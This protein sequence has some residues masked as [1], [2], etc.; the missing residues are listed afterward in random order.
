M[1]DVVGVDL[2]A[3]RVA[4]LVAGQSYVE[5]MSDSDV[6]GALQSDGYEPAGLKATRGQLQSAVQLLETADKQVV[7]VVLIRVPTRRAHA[8][9]CGYGYQEGS[10]RAPK[11]FALPK[12]R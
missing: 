12:V 9:G 4:A 6:S 7:G 3:R 1:F 2:D 8:Y 10:G 5:D 11:R